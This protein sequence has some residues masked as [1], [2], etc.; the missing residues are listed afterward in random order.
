[1]EVSLRPGHRK[2]L[3]GTFVEEA[4]DGDRG[5]VARIEGAVAALP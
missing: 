3:A 2:R 4:A 5:D 1:M